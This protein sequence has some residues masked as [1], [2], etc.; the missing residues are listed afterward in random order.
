MNVDVLRH[1]TGG[2]LRALQALHKANVV[3]KNLRHSCIFMDNNGEVRV[4]EY[5][6]ESRIIEILSIEGSI[7][8]I[9]VLQLFTIDKSCSLLQTIDTL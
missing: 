2:V 9:L 1:I 6:L 7:N 4:S 8:N 3:H 5:S